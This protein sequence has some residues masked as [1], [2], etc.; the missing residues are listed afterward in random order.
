MSSETVNKIPTSKNPTEFLASSH[1]KIGQEPRWLANNNP[2]AYRSTFKND[3]PPQPLGQRHKPKL[4]Q[5]ADI[6]HKDETIGDNHFSVTKEHYD[7]KPLYKTGLGDLPYSL[8]ATNFKMDADEKIKSFDTTHN[9]YFYEKPLKDI[10]DKSEMKDWTKS[11]I[12][13]GDREKIKWLQSDYKSHFLPMKT[14]HTN[15]KGVGTM[16]MTI[17]GDMRIHQD[18]LYN[19]TMKDCFPSKP[20]RKITVDSKVRY[21]VSHIPQGDKDKCNYMESTQ[22]DDYRPPLRSESTRSESNQILDKLQSTNVQMGDARL[23]SFR[24][25]VQATYKHNAGEGRMRSAKKPINKSNLPEGDTDY[26]KSIERFTNT[27]HRSQYKKPPSEYRN[28]KIDGSQIRTSSN[29]HLGDDHRMSSYQTTMDDNFRYQKSSFQKAL[30]NIHTSSIPTDFYKNLNTQPTYRSDYTRQD[31]VARLE[32]NPIALNNLKKSSV[33]IK[34]PS[35]QE[36]TTTH[37]ETFTPKETSR[38]R[39]LQLGKLQKSSVPLGTLSQ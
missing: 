18:A 31:E 23:N 15:P 27:T 17:K 32:P 38:V 16:P 13:Q 12:P 9:T 8:T 24:S 29:V 7:L 22:K 1:F 33:N 14:E 20:H 35:F 26:F 11:H 21:P 2:A 37:K 3:Y 19:T 4:L 30:G 25:T 36:F 34:D 5:P 6:M 39:I 28:P 10:R